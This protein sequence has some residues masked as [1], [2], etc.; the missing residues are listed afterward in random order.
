M[1]S[2]SEDVL[3]CKRIDLTDED[4]N[5]L[6]TLRATKKNSGLWI[7]NEATG[8]LLF[9]SANNEY[10]ALGVYGPDNKSCPLFS[11]G[12]MADGTLVT[13]EESH[14]TYQKI[15]RERSEPETPHT[16]QG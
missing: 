16:S 12:V 3:R 4:G 10:S 14:S 15:Q 8:H 13:P 7:E 1:S 9:L 6:L 11:V 2:T 5:T